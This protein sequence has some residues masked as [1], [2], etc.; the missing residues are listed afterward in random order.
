MKLRVLIEEFLEPENL[1][2]P[3]GYKFYCV[4]G[5]VRFVHFIFDRGS[6]TKEQILD[7]HGQDLG[8]GLCASFT[9]S[10]GFRKPENWEEMIRVAEQLSKGF[11]CVRVDLYSSHGRTL[12]GQMTF[13][14]M[15]GCHKGEGQRT[16]RTFLDFDR[17]SYKPLVHTRL[18]RPQ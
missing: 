8:T 3:A 15:A 7:R 9:L 4:G 17:R 10:K 13:W 6:D 16:L 2:P 14:P 11:K 5:S 1:T 12:A 18:S